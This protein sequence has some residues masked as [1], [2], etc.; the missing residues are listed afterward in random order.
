M[1]RA[2]VA[3]NMV[4]LGLVVALAL[5]LAACGQRGPLRLPDKG[6]SKVQTP[7]QPESPT[8]P[9]NDT[10]HQEKP[11]DKHDQTKSPNPQ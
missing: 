6:P 2:H 7:S 8:A 4:V 5:V 9:P 1:T 11:G 3:R 10:D